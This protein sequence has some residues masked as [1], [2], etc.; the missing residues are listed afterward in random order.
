MRERGARQRL[1]RRALVAMALGGTLLAGCAGG[2]AANRAGLDHSDNE[3]EASPT[4]SQSPGVEEDN[5]SPTESAPED[6]PNL[7]TAEPNVSLDP[8][9]AIPAVPDA[10]CLAAFPNGDLLVGTTG[11]NLSRVT[12][13]GDITDVGQLQGA[14]TELLA[15]AIPP[16]DEPDTLYAYYAGASSSSVAAYGYDPTEPDGAQVNSTNQQIVRYLPHAD[17]RSGGALTFGP[18]DGLLY[19]GIGD[20]G[21]AELATSP[22]SGAGKILRIEQNT[23]L[24]VDGGNIATESLVHSSGHGDIR[25]LAWDDVNRLWSVEVDPDGVTEVNAVIPQARY[26]EEAP[27]HSWE[28]SE[29]DPVGL[30]YGAVSLWVPSRGQGLWRLPLDLSA[31]EVSGAPQLLADDLTAPTAV[32]PDASDGPLRVLIGDVVQPYGIS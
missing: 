11:G 20:A 30:A 1:L 8:G 28:A 19:V 31:A 3:D 23:P 14:L 6:P 5:E 9:T 26:D 17:S 24:P 32:L 4:G 27:K 29:V 13:Q 22:T 16:D 15:L 25:G 10:C 12:E 7:P 18:E 2:P 21:N